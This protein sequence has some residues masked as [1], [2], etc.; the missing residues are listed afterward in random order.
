MCS[1][2]RAKCHTNVCF[3]TPLLP[4]K[5]DKQFNTIL[6]TLISKGAGRC[7]V[8]LQERISTSEDVCHAN[9]QPRKGWC[10][11]VLILALGRLQSHQN[12][13]YMTVL[14][15]KEENPRLLLSNMSELVRQYQI[16][17][18]SNTELLLC[19]IYKDGERKLPAER[20]PIC[21]IRKTSE[22]VICV[23][24]L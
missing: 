19:V 7:D 1:C 9:R 21:C 13:R 5:R 8:I 18:F 4:E 22:G 24:F 6:I 14:P 15:N 23:C 2:S 17:P 11:D 16:L 10:P 12:V 3:V 20:N